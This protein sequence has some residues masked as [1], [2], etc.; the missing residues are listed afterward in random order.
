MAVIVVLVASL[1]GVKSAV[2]A[3]LPET[4]IHRKFVTVGQYH[5]NFDKISFVKQGQLANGRTQVALHFKGPHQSAL[6]FDGAEAD[7]LQR[8][9]QLSEVRL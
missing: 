7:R 6:T 5:I 9:R 1:A 2:Y 8:R 4:L 3:Q